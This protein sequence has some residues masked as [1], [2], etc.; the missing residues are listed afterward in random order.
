M[1]SSNKKTIFRTGEKV[2]IYGE[3]TPVKSF[4]RERNS[5]SQRDLSRSPL[6]ERL[7]EGILKMYQRGG[8]ES[9]KLDFEI[10]EGP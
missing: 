5:D 10:Q 7:N 4:T 1:N 9:K 8:P 6:E 2:T 3:R